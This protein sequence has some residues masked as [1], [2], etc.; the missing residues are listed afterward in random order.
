MFAT[1]HSPTRRI[2]PT[3]KEWI[4]HGYQ[5]RA[6][7]F[8][9]DR[10]AAALFLDPGLGKTSVTLAAF[11]ILRSEGIAKKMLVVAPLR[12]CQLVWTQE[13]QEWTQFRHLKFSTLHGPKKG[14]RLNDDS[15][16]FLINPE[17]I[18]WLVSQY[19]GKPWPFDTVT[20][21][22]LTKFKNASSLRHKALMTK[23]S[24]VQ[25]RWGLTGSPI[26]NGYLDLFGQMKTLDGGASLGNYYTR[27]RDKYFEADFSGFK[28]LL[29]RGSSKAIEA[30]IKPY[31]LRMAA[32]DYLELPPRIDDIISVVMPKKAR[33]IYEEMKKEMMAVLEGT[34]VEAGNAAAVYSKLKQMANGAVYAGDG[35][36]EPKKV[37]HIHDAKIEALEELIEEL[38][39]TPLLV[40]YEF[41]HDLARIQKALGGNIPYIGSGVT[42]KQAEQIEKDWNANKIPVLLA[43]PASAGHGLNFQKGNA[44]HIAWFSATWDYELYDQFIKR[45]LRQGNEATTVFNHI[46]IVEDT[47]DIKTREAILVKG[48]TQDAFHDALNSEIYRTGKTAVPPHGTEEKENTMVRKLQ[49]R[50]VEEDDI[51]EEDEEEVSTSSRK[52]KRVSSRSK[53]RGKPRDEEEEVDEEEEEDDLEEEEEKPTRKTSRRKFSRKVREALDGDEEEEEEEEETSEEDDPPKRRSRKVTKKEAPEEKFGSSRPDDDEKTSG[54]T[55]QVGTFNGKSEVIVIACEKLINEVTKKIGK[56]TSEELKD[57][58]SIMVNVSHLLSD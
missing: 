5:V 8:L 6:V 49:R 7:N 29:R 34:V 58:S 2:E 53:L 51:E 4:P 18:S 31:V 10:Q 50:G 27:F 17:G 54:Q 9:V 43:H 21:D 22:E 36:F 32:D 33:V 16:I 42:A 3:H 24:K 28:Y 40:G 30:A 1:S 35:V 48:F 37:V 25:R 39:G 52:S 55:R 19:K 23:M 46:F 26:P 20:I 38:A 15:D 47:I 56:S 44:F 41:R 13:G 45:V 12:V 14:D 57:L 11:D